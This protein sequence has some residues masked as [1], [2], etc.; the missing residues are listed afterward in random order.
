MGMVDS[1]FDTVIETLDGA[2]V[3]E[4]GCDGEM[5][6]SF[7]V[8]DMD[9]SRFIHEFRDRTAVVGRGFSS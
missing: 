5:L 4:S 6:C 7:D 3:G 2:T 8:V 1:V 9:E